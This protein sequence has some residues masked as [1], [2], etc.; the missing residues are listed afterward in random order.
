ML[1]RYR[2]DPA[3]ALRGYEGAR[4]HRTAR[5]Q[6]VSRKQGRL[7][8]LSGPEAIIRNFA[9]RLMGGEKLRERYDWLYNWRPP[10]F[11]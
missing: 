5:V 4:R 7:Y 9:M 1:G 10:E 8:A 6:Q 3:D 2:G 11:T